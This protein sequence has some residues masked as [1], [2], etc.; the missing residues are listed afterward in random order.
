[1]K[2]YAD[3]FAPIDEEEIAQE[4]NDR[5]VDIWEE[6]TNTCA[7]ACPITSQYNYNYQLCLP[8]GNDIDISIEE[9]TE[10]VTVIS[11]EI[12]SYR[13]LQQLV[14]QLRGN[15]KSIRLTSKKQVLLDWL[16]ANA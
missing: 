13:E 11:Y 12:Y 5:P 9:L 15:D 8:A 6:S 14:K 1:M 4:D 16:T 7:F 2:D 3:A 10:Q